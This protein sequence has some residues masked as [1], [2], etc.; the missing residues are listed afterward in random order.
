VGEASVGFR[1]SGPLIYLKD[2]RR[3]C[4]RFDASAFPEDDSAFTYR[5]DRVA[6]LTELDVRSSPKPTQLLRGN[7]MTRWARSRLIFR[8]TLVTRPRRWQSQ[9][10]SVEFRCRAILRS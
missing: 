1:R 9:A 6:W 2:R 8:Q 5:R 3:W 7:E 4:G 10:A